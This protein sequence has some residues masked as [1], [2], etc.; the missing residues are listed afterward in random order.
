MKKVVVFLV[1]IVV[2]L[3]A[4]YGFFT[5]T[6]KNNGRLDIYHADSPESTIE[7]LQT[8]PG[9]AYEDPEFYKSPEWI[10]TPG[11]GTIFH[12]TPDFF[13]KEA[14]IVFKSVGDGQFN[15]NLLG[16]YRPVN[17]TEEL[18][19]IKVE[20]KDVTINDEPIIEGPVTV[21][22]NDQ[23]GFSY[24]A[25]NDEVYTLKFKYRAPLSF[26]GAKTPAPQEE[27][28]E[29]QPAEENYEEQPAEEQPAEENYEEQ[30]VE[31]QPAE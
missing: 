7:V 13:W 9:F 19:E 16:D 21:W 14:E 17:G 15:I 10:Q 25:V 24:S 22:H 20:Y 1:A 8:T 3:G 4:A 23:K 6:Q 29:E 12:F 2:L 30:P 5:T 28:T 31:E 18:Q 11:Q 27:Y 26:G